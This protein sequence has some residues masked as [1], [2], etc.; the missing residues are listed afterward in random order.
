MVLVFNCP[1][2][3]STSKEAASGPPRVY[4][5][6][7]PSGSVAAIAVP[8]LTPTSKFSATDRVVAFPS[9]KTGTSFASVMLIVPAIVS[10]RLPSETVT[11]IE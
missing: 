11:V 7:L 4:V 10:V 5:N 6:V 8:M 3:L 9:V 2:E 1:V